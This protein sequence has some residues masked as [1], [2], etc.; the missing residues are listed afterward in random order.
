MGTAT[1]IWSFSIS[2]IINRERNLEY[3]LSEKQILKNAT[4]FVIL[5]T[6]A[7][8]E[9]SNANLPL[10]H[11]MVKFHPKSEYSRDLN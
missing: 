1:G 4:Y 5:S 3:S 11:T 7:F 10:P 9:L 8:Y 6:G 2:G